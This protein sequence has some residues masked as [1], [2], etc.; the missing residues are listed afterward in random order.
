VLVRDLCRARSAEA[1]GRL[2]HLP[3]ILHRFHLRTGEVWTLPA[4]GMM[5]T[6]TEPDTSAC[7]PSRWSRSRSCRCRRRRRTLFRNGT[8]G[9]ARLC[10]A[11]ERWGL[12]GG[13]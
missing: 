11:A 10:R 6:V 1:A 8:R 9:A 7:S 2:S 12:G 3:R 13:G 5:P 4:S